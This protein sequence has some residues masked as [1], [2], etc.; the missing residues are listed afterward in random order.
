M[1]GAYC[2][3][4]PKTRSLCCQSLINQNVAAEKNSATLY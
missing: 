4:L 2:P 3:L 1:L